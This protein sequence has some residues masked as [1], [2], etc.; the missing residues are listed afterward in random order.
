VKQNSAVRILLFF[1][2]ISMFA[3]KTTTI[4]VRVFHSFTGME[5]PIR[6]AFLNTNSEE[7]PIYQKSRDL[8]REK[9]GPERV[10]GDR[11]PGGLG[12]GLFQVHDGHGKQ[13]F[14]PMPTGDWEKYIPLVSGDSK[15]E[16]SEKVG[17]EMNVTK[18]SRH[19]LLFQI[20]D[21]KSFELESAT[22][23]YKAEVT[24]NWQSQNI[25]EIMPDMINAL[26]RKFPGKTQ[27]SGGRHRQDLRAAPK[28]PIG[29]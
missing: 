10:P 1:L 26:F 15:S 4:T 13:R 25:E 9:V 14:R 20:I 7:D 19:R 12:P 17:L 24:A 27:P 22:A 29:V 21:R 18:Q 28:S 16:K 11:F 6:Y 5:E 8:V 23:L 3:C 2:I